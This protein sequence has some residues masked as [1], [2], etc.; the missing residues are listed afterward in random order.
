[1]SDKFGGGRDPQAYL[2]GK[3]QLA[4]VWQQWRS[5]PVALIDIDG[6]TYS[7]S[8][9]VSYLTIW[10]EVFYS[11]FLRMMLSPC[12]TA[13]CLPDYDLLPTQTV[14]R[15]HWLTAWLFTRW[16]QPLLPL[17]LTSL[18]TLLCNCLLIVSDLDRVIFGCCLF[19]F[20][21][22]FFIFYTVWDF[23]SLSP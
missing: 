5:Q 18:L 2:V 15:N 22:M 3:W 12:L 10:S 16:H 6:S 23:L 19:I 21:F 9:V 1:M 20:P 4:W 13:A 11:S 8:E 7:R 17:L 14:L